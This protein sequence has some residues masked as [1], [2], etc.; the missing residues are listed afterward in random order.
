[1]HIH[2]VLGMG[3]LHSLGQGF[4]IVLFH[5]LQDRLTPAHQGDFRSIGLCG[6]DGAQYRC[7]RCVVAAHGVKND[8]H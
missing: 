4:D 6:F 5:N 3:D 8:L 2:N 1:M 7:F